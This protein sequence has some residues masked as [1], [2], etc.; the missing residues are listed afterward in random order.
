MHMEVEHIFY[1]IRICIVKNSQIPKRIEFT[2]ALRLYES[3]KWKIRVFDDLFPRIQASFKY[4]IFL[5][6]LL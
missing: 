6:I 2:Y 5:S 1:A 4:F 3:D